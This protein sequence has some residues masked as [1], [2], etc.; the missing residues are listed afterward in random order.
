MPFQEHCIDIGYD[1]CY[2][3]LFDQESHRQRRDRLCRLSSRMVAL[4]VVTMVVLPKWTF[5]WANPLRERAP[6]T[7]IPLHAI[8]HADIIIIKNER[9]LCI[10]AASIS[11]AHLKYGVECSNIIDK[12]RQIAPDDLRAGNCALEI[13]FKSPRTVLL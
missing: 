4:H 13:A 11:G 5:T 9:A 10:R 7:T 6:S 8:I 2:Y 3:L 12:S 1:M